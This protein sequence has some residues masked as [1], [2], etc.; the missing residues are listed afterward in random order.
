MAIPPLPGVHRDRAAP[1]L[2]HLWRL[3]RLRAEAA[4]AP[5]D[6]RLRHVVALSVLRRSGGA[7]QQALAE[8]LRIDRTNLVGLLN[9]LEARGLVLRMRDAGDRRRH[10]VELTPA[11]A[12]R[13]D[14]AEAL[15]AGV[16]DDVL[17]ALDADERRTL[18]ALLQKATGGCAPALVAASGD[19]ELVAAS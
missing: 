7:T 19:E 10:N 1:P 6:L 14:E 16:E 13:L 5:M 2:H 11:G 15:L 4:I 18:C 12:V 3:M 17:G 8:M 9:E